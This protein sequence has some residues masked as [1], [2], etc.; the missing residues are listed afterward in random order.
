MKY[1]AQLNLPGGYVVNAPQGLP[2]GGENSVANIVSSSIYLLLSVAGVLS[3]LFTLY[4]GIKWMTSG[5]EEEKLAGA[6]MTLTFAIGG[7]VLTLSAFVIINIL[8]RYFGVNFYSF[9]F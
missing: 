8:A 7:L 6:R 5:G 9:S 4:G 1:L 3:L 2:Q